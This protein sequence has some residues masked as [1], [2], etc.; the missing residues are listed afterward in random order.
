MSLW[1]SIFKE[2]KESKNSDIKERFA[3]IIKISTCQGYLV[4]KQGGKVLHDIY[5][6]VLNAGDWLWF[7]FT[8]STGVREPDGTPI[9]ISDAAC[10]W[11]T[12]PTEM[13]V[14]LGTSSMPINSEFPQSILPY[15]TSDGTITD[16]SNAFNAIDS[17]FKKD[18]NWCNQW[19]RRTERVK[20]LMEGQCS[21][22]ITL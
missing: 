19:S 11:F 18:K 8:T 14:N 7:I 15:V 22:W 12:I 10:F 2:K 5:P 1:K 9:I 16:S 6:N 4:S 21:N 17:Y 3:K 20:N 13:K